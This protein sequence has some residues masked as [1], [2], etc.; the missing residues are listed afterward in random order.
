M[1]LPTWT[2][3]RPLDATYAALYGDLP[4][5]SI[6]PTYFSEFGFTF[7]EAN[8]AS[9]VNVQ[10][11][12]SLAGVDFGYN[13]TTSAKDPNGQTVTGLPSRW[14]VSG[15]ADGYSIHF[16]L[17]NTDVRDCR[18]GACSTVVSADD[19]APFFSMM[20]SR[21]A[22]PRRPPPPQ[23]QEIPEPGSLALVA[24]WRCLPGGSLRC[25]GLW[26]DSRLRSGTRRGGSFRRW[27]CLFSG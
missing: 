11:N 19:F 7:L 27:F 14:D 10:D 20:P 12:A 15:V 16:D 24:L 5:H 25:R 8:K 3:A 2:T 21:V 1:S 18:Q 22:T 26:S 13:P 9:P 4:T 23:Q 6:F 17:Y